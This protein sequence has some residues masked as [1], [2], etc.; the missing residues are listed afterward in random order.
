MTLALSKIFFYKLV[1]L[2]VQIGP[3]QSPLNAHIMHLKQLV[4]NTFLT[5]G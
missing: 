2:S 5:A 3:L 1:L 4:S